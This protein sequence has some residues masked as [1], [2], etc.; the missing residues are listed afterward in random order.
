MSFQTRRVTLFSIALISAVVVGYLSFSALSPCIGFRHPTYWLYCKGQCTN[1][2]TDP[3]NCG[4][5]GNQCTSGASCSNGRCLCPGGQTLCNGTCVNTSTDPKNCGTCGKLCGTA[6]TLPTTCSA[7]VC[8]T[9]CPSTQQS[10]GAL[11]LY[12]CCPAAPS[13]TRFCTCAQGPTDHCLSGWWACGVGQQLQ[14]PPMACQPFQP[15]GG[16]AL[17]S[18]PP[19]MCLG[20]PNQVP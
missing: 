18:P 15:F 6:Y 5:C 9:T 11:A 3:D 4:A 13:T 1:T 8:A 16:P 12:G 19:A 14:G 2:D 20:A 17:K 10:C 7:G